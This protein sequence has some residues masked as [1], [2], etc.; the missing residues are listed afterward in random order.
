MNCMYLQL[1]IFHISNLDEYFSFYHKF[2]YALYG[3]FCYL[4]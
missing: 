1:S 2:F 3:R 4:F